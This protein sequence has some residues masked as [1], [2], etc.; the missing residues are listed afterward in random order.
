MNNEKNRKER[1]K[2]KKEKGREEQGEVKRGRDRGGGC[3]VYCLCPLRGRRNLVGE[4]KMRQKHRLITGLGTLIITFNKACA[5]LRCNK[6]FVMMR[7]RVKTVSGVGGMG[8]VSLGGWHPR[9]G[10][11]DTG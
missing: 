2:G 5:L 6:Q 4:G 7:V 8:P 1:G 11:V 10:S 9:L 3:V